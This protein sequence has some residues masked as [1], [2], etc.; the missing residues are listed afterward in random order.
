[1]VTSLM[2]ITA[3]IWIFGAILRVVEDENSTR[4]AHLQPA[5]V[6][7]INP[8][9]CSPRRCLAKH[10]FG[11]GRAVTFLDEKSAD[12]WSALLF[13]EIDWSVTAILGCRG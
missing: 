5:R 12:P 7:N 1:M 10:Q 6:V 4:A 2:F 3:V 8:Y 13:F 11:K 9:T